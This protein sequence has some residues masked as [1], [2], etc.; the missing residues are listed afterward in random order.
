[1][2][3]NRPVIIWLYRK[4]KAWCLKLVIFFLSTRYE[5]NIQY[6]FELLDYFRQQEILDRTGIILSFLLLGIPNQ[7]LSRRNFTL[8]HTSVW[9]KPNDQDRNMQ[10]PSL[11]KCVHGK[12]P[13]WPTAFSYDIMGI[14]FPDPE[15]EPFGG[16]AATTTKRQD[17]ATCEEWNGE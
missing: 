4:Y 15:L 5:S 16:A 6:S 8:S 2:I 10:Y 12:V 17:K 14:S 1:M 7:R 13:S 3:Y 11:R 9:I